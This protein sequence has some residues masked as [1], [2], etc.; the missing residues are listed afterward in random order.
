MPIPQ[1]DQFPVLVALGKSQGN[2]EVLEILDGSKSKD[3]I[4][5]HL[6]NIKSQFQDKQKVDIL[7]WEELELRKLVKLEQDVAYQESLT[8]DQ[9]KVPLSIGYCGRVCDCGAF[10]RGNA[11]TRS[12]RPGKRR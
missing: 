10:R 2:V 1:K 3:E 8:K 4:L 12:A 6:W 9:I 11:T 7:A 5:I